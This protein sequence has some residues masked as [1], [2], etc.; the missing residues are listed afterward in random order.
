MTLLPRAFLEAARQRLTDDGDIT[1]IDA[2]PKRYSPDEPRR[3]KGDPDG[4]QWTAGAVDLGDAKWSADSPVEAHAYGT[5]AW[6][7]WRKSLTQDELDAID[8]YL[9]DSPS[10][11]DPLRGDEEP[12]D[13]AAETWPELDSALAK[14]KFKTDTMLYRGMAEDSLPN[15]ELPEVGQAFVDL[16]YPSTSLSREI[17]ANYG[18]YTVEIRAKAGS[19]GGFVDR[20][21]S[22]QAKTLAPQEAEVLLPRRSSFKVVWVGGKTIRVEYT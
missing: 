2:K 3:P 14:G 19:H 11:N 9:E 4:G 22:A 13:W 12:A 7:A 21:N 15:G 8:R 1:F 16:G 6:A 17:A 5:A 20:S 10:I 18:D